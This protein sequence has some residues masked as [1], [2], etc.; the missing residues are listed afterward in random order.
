MTNSH[1]LRITDETNPGTNYAQEGERCGSGGT[2]AEVF[3]D[4]ED[5]LKCVPYSVPGIERQWQE[6]RCLRISDTAKAVGKFFAKFPFDQAENPY[7]AGNMV[8]SLKGHFLK[9]NEAEAGEENN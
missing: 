8:D 4:C 9:M 3:P 7:F 2:T 5:G 1:G 6:K